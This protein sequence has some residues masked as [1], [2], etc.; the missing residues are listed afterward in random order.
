MKPGARIAPDTARSAGAGGLVHLAHAARL[1]L[2]VSGFAAQ[3]ARV[4]RHARRS[5]AQHG[6]G[7]GAAITRQQGVRLVSF[8]QAVRRSEDVDGPPIDRVHRVIA[9]VAEEIID[10]FE[11]RSDV[12]AIDPVDHVEALA[13]APVIHPEPTY[14]ACASEKSRRVGHYRCSS[15]RGRYKRPKKPATCHRSVGHQ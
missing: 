5:A 6:I 13:R 3:V 1:H 12:V 15:D 2:H 9:P 14:I 4:P 10:F 8:H 11:R 7:G